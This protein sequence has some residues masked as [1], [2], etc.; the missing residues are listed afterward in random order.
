MGGAGHRKC[1]LVDRY[2][3][4]NRWWHALKRHWRIHQK[5]FRKWASLAA[6]GCSAIMHGKT[7]LQICRMSIDGYSMAA[8]CH[9]LFDFN[10][11]GHPENCVQSESMWLKKSKRSF[12]VKTK[13]LLMAWLFVHRFIFRLSPHKGFRL[14]LLKVFGANISNTCFVHSSALI[15]MPWNL[16]MGERSSIDFDALVYSLGK[17]VIGDYVSISYKVN[18]NTGSHDYS[19]PFFSLITKPVIINSGAFIG[20]DVYISPGV[21]IGQ[22]AVIG[23]RSV[24]TK[25]LPANYVCMGHPCKPYK[26]R[27]MKGSVQE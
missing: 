1:R 12:S 18:I 21:E 7:S 9:L 22:M 16:T 25:S 23:A 13:L 4:L 27:E 10:N 19:D 14:W 24:V 20:A 15:Y 17:V 2:R 26:V 5:C 11:F 3:Q 8:K 6:I